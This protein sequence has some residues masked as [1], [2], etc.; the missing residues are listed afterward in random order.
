MGSGHGKYL[1]EGLIVVIR[2]VVD[3]VDESRSISIKE[4]RE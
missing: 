2:D 4:N 3:Y 1:I